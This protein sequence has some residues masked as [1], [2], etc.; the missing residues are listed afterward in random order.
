MD[1][2]SLEWLCSKTKRMLVAEPITIEFTRPANAI[3]NKKDNY[4][5]LQCLEP[6]AP[7]TKPF[8]ALKHKLRTLLER[9]LNVEIV[10]RPKLARSKL[11]MEHHHH[12]YHTPWC[13]GRDIADYLISRG[14]Q[15]SHHLLDLGCG[16]IRAGV[17][18]IGYLDSGRYFGV[19]AHLE[20]LEAAVKYEI[21]LHRLEHKQP[22]F[23][24]SAT[25][26]IG[27]FQRAFDVI[28]ASSVLMHLSEAQLDLALRSI[29]TTLSPSG[30]LVVLPLPQLPLDEATLKV[31]YG[32]ALS[33]METRRS[34]F[35]GEE[36]TWFE[37]MLA[38]I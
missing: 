19:D 30:K 32:L 22:R 16:S 38:K 1:S 15:T 2:N 21:P 24:H 18:L 23:L 4:S 9:A 17:W 13:H 12:S 33:H 34:S 31:K 10:R 27:H 36:T 6:R 8:L 3:I 29:T 28:L 26:E 20:S 11:L 25:F 35:T 37:M 14:L 5:W 7:H